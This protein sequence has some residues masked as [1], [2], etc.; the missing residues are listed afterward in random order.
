MSQSTLIEKTFEYGT[1]AILKRGGTYVVRR[2]VCD[3]PLV[4]ECR[5]IRHAFNLY[6]R[7]IRLWVR[8][9][10]RESSSLG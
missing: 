2:W 4:D 6:S 10:W 9:G 1:V 7:Y 5:D 3:G 8:K